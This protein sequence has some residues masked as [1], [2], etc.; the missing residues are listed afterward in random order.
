VIVWPFLCTFFPYIRKSAAHLDVALFCCLSALAS[1]VSGRLHINTSHGSSLLSTL[2][3]SKPP[4]PPPPIHP[5]Q[6]HSTMPGKHVRFVQNNLVYS[7]APTTPS[8]TYSPYSPSSSTGLLTPPSLHRTTLPLPV[9]PVQ[10]HPLLACASNGYSTSSATSS[11]LIYDLTL[12]PQTAQCANSYAPSSS[13]ARLPLPPHV[14]AE[15]AT[16]PPQPHLTLSCTEQ[17]PW[18][19]HIVAA[20]PHVGVTVGDVLHC[21][22]SE[23]RRSATEA[24]FRSLP[25]QAA[26]AFATKSY[27]DRCRRLASDPRAFAHEKSKGL[28]RVDFL[29]GRVAWNGLSSSK[30]G[31]NV[32]VLNVAST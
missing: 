23:L 29:L 5:Q 21:L 8:L 17:L 20:H 12:P 14:L 32:W 30:L 15:A 25:T 19:I 22:Y 6:S 7:P 10:I 11:A 26:Q 18:P 2:V 1:L 9:I 3:P 31:P 24:E 13:S 16:S 4:P 28:K 27:E